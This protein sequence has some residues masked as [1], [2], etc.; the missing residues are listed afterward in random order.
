MKKQVLN[1]EEGPGSPG[2]WSADRA[3]GPDL[4]ISA[5]HGHFKQLDHLPRPHFFA[6]Y[7][8]N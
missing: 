8:T 6:F 2:S 5:E 7:K 3:L 1:P 4:R